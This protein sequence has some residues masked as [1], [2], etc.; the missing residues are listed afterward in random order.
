MVYESLDPKIALS[1][2][3]I[4][5]I[6]AI[7]IWILMVFLGIHWYQNKKQSVRYLTLAFIFY[8]CAFSVL[9]A[10]MYEVANTG[11]KMEVYIF[12][13]PFGLISAMI[14]H[15]FIILFTVSFF[16]IKS[17][18]PRVYIILNLLISVSILHP[19]NNYGVLAGDLRISDI[20]M[21][22]SLSMVLFSLFLFTR[23]ALVIMKARKL[24]DDSDRYSKIGFQ[25]LAWAQISMILFYLFY[26]FET[27]AY[28]LFDTGDFTP[29]FF[30][31]MGSIGFCVLFFYLG[32]LLP[33]WIL[34][35]NLSEY[36]RE[37][38]EEKLKASKQQIL[39]Q[40]F[41]KKK[42]TN[43]HPVPQLS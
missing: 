11:L 27:I 1:I 5:I 21:Y 33:V 22:T 28:T 4:Y 31:A 17:K 19:K 15:I 10:G 14:G 26:T 24:V 6:L 3:L 25:C 8:A 43:C 41:Q 34:N 2:F 36:F 13:L 9:A 37:I 40:I 23:I 38:L 30:I 16:G 35:K 39:P 32:I 29:F 42:K 12:S 20:R 18:T 7:F